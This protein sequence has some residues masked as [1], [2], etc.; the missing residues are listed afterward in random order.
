MNATEARPYRRRTERAEGDL[1]SIAVVHA[2]HLAR[3]TTPSSWARDALIEAAAR[4]R[5][6]RADEREALTT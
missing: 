2:A 6:A 3:G 1:V 5:E 4:L